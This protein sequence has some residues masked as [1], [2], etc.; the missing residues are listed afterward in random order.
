MTADPTKNSSDQNQPGSEG[1]DENDQKEESAEKTPNASPGPAEGSEAGPVTE[2][3]EVHGD[4]ISGHLPPELWSTLRGPF[5]PSDVRLINIRTDTKY[6]RGLAQPVVKESALIHRL[7]E[8]LGPEGWSVEFHREGSQEYRCRLHIGS[9]FRDAIA[10]EGE[11]LDSCLQAL[12]LAARQFGIAAGLH[13][14]PDIYVEKDEDGNI[15]NF[16]QIIEELRDAGAV[17]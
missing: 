7:N 2:P 4:D 8:T 3:S 5:D 9:A 10:E 1:K 15:K 13:G 11:H 14:P 12:R 17:K 6:G 16:D